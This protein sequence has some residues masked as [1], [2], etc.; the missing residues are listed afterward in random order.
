M[1]TAQGR[2]GGVLGSISVDMSSLGQEP[3]LRAVARSST[4]LAR[5]IL[6]ASPRARILSQRHVNAIA[7]LPPDATI[8]PDCYALHLRKL[9]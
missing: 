9:A 8:D 5:D 1:P 4:H 7:G 6:N 2:F 3:V